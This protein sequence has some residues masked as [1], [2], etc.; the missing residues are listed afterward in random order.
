MVIF[1]IGF[2][3]GMYLKNQVYQ[4]FAVVVLVREYKGFS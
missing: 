2:I 4:S 3:Q 1:C